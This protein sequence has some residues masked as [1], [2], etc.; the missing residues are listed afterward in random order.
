ML[1]NLSL[2]VS[3]LPI[4]VRR[5]LK[6]VNSNKLRPR[7][8]GKRSSR[9][10]GSPAQPSYPGQA[11]FSYKMHTATNRLCEKHRI[12]PRRRVTCLTGSSLVDGR[13]ALPINTLARLLGSTRSLLTRLSRATSFLYK[14]SL[15]LT[16]LRE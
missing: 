4:S 15:K 6:T 13:V 11:T 12:G 2:E 3:F 1:S 7:F 16:R 9:I 8:N 5:Q 14:R 10:E